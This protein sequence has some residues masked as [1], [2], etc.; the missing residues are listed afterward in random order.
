MPILALWLKSLFRVPPCVRNGD[1]VCNNLMTD[2]GQKTTA[3]LPWHPV[4]DRCGQNTRPRWTD[5]GRCRASRLVPWRLAPVVF[6]PYIRNSPQEWKR[7]R[8]GHLISLVKSVGWREKIRFRVLIRSGAG[9]LPPLPNRGQP[10]PG[11]DSA[12]E[13][14]GCCDR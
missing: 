12:D 7:D 6:L 1:P 13:R 9:R 5:E 4:E 2:H 11:T 14:C 10:N 3:V 8:V